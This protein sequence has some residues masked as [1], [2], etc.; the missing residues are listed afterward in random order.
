MEI[1]WRLLSVLRQASKDVSYVK[2]LVISYVPK[3]GLQI[4]FLV[5]RDL[6]KYN[7]AKKNKR[8]S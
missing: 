4:S 7:S 6:G 3:A 2:D 8:Y 5:Q 1:L